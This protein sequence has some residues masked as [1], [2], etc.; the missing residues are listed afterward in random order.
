MLTFV[1]VSQIHHRVLQNSKLTLPVFE[2]FNVTN[3]SK[4][5]SPPENKKH[6]PG[7]RY[8]AFVDLATT[9]EC[10]DAIATLDGVDRWNWRIKISPAF[11][12]TPPQTN[13]PNESYSSGPHGKPAPSKRLFVA[14]LPEF[15]DQETTE[16]SMRELFE[17]FELKSISKLFY[18]KEPPKEGEGN[19][20][21]CFVEVTD[22]EQA[23]RARLE[24]DWKVM[25]DGEVRVKTATPSGG[26]RKSEDRAS[27][28]ER[29]S[30]GWRD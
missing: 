22:F 7:N 29:P 6:L 14:G 28:D 24:L 4:Q 21:F 20:C 15:L 5:F 13:K 8:Y 9:Q 19:H 16:R 27:R 2:K 23:D 12:P 25:W 30:R 17:G 11:T 18:P 1:D 26:G 10:E 3:V